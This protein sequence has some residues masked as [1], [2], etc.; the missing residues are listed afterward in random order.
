[1]D[2]WIQTQGIALYLLTHM[3]IFPFNNHMCVDTCVAV[4]AESPHLELHSIL[5]FRVF[6]FMSTRTKLSDTLLSTEEK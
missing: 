3:P 6:I 5:S 4:W 1:M 2:D